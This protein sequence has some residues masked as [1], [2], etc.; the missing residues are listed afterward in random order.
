MTG[1]KLRKHIAKALQSRSQAIRTALDSYNTA[2]HALT[3]PRQQLEWK[4]VIEYAFLADFDLLRDARQDISHRPWATP[5]GRLAM[6]LYYKISRAQEEVDRLDIE[7]R[8]VATYLRDEHHY[9][10]YMEEK[11]R[12]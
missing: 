2:A 5:A 3:P 7:V 12:A 10:R 9:L 1:Y 6:D 4:Q 8:R 11:V